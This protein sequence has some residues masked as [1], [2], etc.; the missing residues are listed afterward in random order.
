VYGVVLFCFRSNRENLAAEKVLKKMEEYEHRILLD[1]VEKKQKTAVMKNMQQLRKRTKEIEVWEYAF[2][3][4]LE[5]K[6]VG[7]EESEDFLRW[8][9]RE[10]LKRG[11]TIQIVAQKIL[12]LF[13]FLKKIWQKYKVKLTDLI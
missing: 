2:I 13:D 5:G 4:D 12:R 3:H 11:Q 8:E 1:E 7:I 10:K 6:L 9:M